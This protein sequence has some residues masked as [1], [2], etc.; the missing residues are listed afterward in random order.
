MGKDA[1]SFKRAF[2]HSGQTFSQPITRPGRPLPGTK[3]GTL[4]LTRRYAKALPQPAQDEIPGEM[5]GQ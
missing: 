4:P 1:C 3:K 2:G 5:V